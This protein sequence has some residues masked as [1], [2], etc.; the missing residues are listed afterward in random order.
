LAKPWQLAESY[1]QHYLI[2]LFQPSADR[3]PPVDP[4]IAAILPESYCRQHRIAP[5]SDI[6][7]LL[8]VAICHPESIQLADEI[9]GLTGR[10]M[11]PFFATRATIERVCDLLFRQDRVSP[12]ASCEEHHG[13]VKPKE[14][15][16]HREAI[17][18][19]TSLLARA[20]AFGATEIVLH[21][22]ES[23][24]TVSARSGS[25]R[26]FVQPPTKQQ[27]ATIVDYLSLISTLYFEQRTDS[28]SGSVRLRI[29]KRRFSATWTDR[30]TPAGRTVSIQL[31]PLSLPKTL[32]TSTTTTSVTPREPV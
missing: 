2:P 27:F 31:S 5:L 8:E 24:L 13:A 19:T 16:S 15:S 30:E 18:Y 6:G 29:G 32:S 26:H 11:R 21:Q 22:C 7:S 1:S 12:D 25:R 20:A 23:T 4:S 10:K 17:Q 28:A 14:Q 3:P 9:Q